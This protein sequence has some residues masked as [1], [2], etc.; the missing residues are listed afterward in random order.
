MCKKSTFD[1][2]IIFWN[3]TVQKIFTQEIQYK[4]SMISFVSN[5]TI[6]RNFA[7]YV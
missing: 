2:W 4:F 5:E 6:E 7:V 1:F 3:I